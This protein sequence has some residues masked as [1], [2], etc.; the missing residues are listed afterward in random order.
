AG[1][2]CRRD[3][4]HSPGAQTRPQCTAGSERAQQR[5]HSDQEIPELGAQHPFAGWPGKDLRLD[6]RPVSCAR[7]GCGG[8]RAGIHKHVILIS[9]LSVTFMPNMTGTWDYL[10]VTAANDQQAKAYDAQIQNVGKPAK[11]L[12][13][14]IVL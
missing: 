7:E 4:R 8:G 11:F 3:C 13:F 10:I 5:Q 9:D 14:A 1:G 12:R 6:L 2:S